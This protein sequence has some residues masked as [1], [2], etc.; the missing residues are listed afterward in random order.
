M[1]FFHGAFDQR[2]LLMEDCPRLFLALR[3]PRYRAFVLTYEVLHEMR[4]PPP[5][6]DIILDYFHWHPDYIQ[7]LEERGRAIQSHLASALSVWSEGEPGK[8]HTG[9]MPIELHV[10]KIGSRFIDDISFEYWRPRIPFGEIA[11]NKTG[12]L[13][14]LR[15]RDTIF[16]HMNSLRGWPHATLGTQSARDYRQV[17]KKEYN[18]DIDYINR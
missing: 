4:L 9:H 8:R 14:G 2:K 13:A 15:R 3:Q 1:L 17:G 12:N 6:V 7:S 10:G 18:G 5:L 16:S 11:T